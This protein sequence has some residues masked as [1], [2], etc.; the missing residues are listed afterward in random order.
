MTVAVGADGGG[1]C[2]DCHTLILAAGLM[3]RS[4]ASRDA[5]RHRN[6]DVRLMNGLP[7]SYFSATASVAL[8]R[9]PLVLLSANDHGVGLFAER[10]DRQHTKT[11]GSVLLGVLGGA[12]PSWPSI[13]TYADGEGN[14]VL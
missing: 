14:V 3:S 4:S 1:C 12:N 9:S 13:F 6:I 11:L 10:L 7:E 8:R 2:R 5:R